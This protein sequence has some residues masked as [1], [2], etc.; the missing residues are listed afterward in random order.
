MAPGAAAQPVASPSAPDLALK[1]EPPAPAPTPAPANTRPVEDFLK[2]DPKKFAPRDPGVEVSDVPVQK[3]KPKGFDKSTAEDV[4]LADPDKIVT[5]KPS[6]EGFPTR[7]SAVQFLKDAGLNEKFHVGN[8]SEDG[9]VFVIPFPT[10][11]K[12]PTLHDKRTLDMTEEWLKVAPDSKVR[13]PKL[14]MTK[15]DTIEKSMVASVAEV[16]HTA[17]GIRVNLVDNLAERGVN[18]IAIHG[19]NDKSKR[20]SHVFVD[21]KV[22]DFVQT[23]GHEATHVLEKTSPDL[24]AR[25][26]EVILASRSKVGHTGY[27]SERMPLYKGRKLRADGKE[28]ITKTMNDEFTA[29]VSGAMWRDPQF[30]QRVYELDSGSTFRKLMYQFMKALNKVLN[31]ARARRIDVTKLVTD[32]DKVR[33]TA[34]QVWAEHAQRNAAP[35][36]AA[37]KGG[38]V[39]GV[40]EQAVWHGTPHRG[41]DKFSTDKIGTRDELY[42]NLAQDKAEPYKPTIPALRKE[43]AALRA[44][45]DCLRG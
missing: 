32:A 5:P 15:I 21:A 20:F 7:E 24:Y 23:I 16:V 3:G 38:T 39:D 27:L 9:T 26:Q 41:I 37:S 44:L 1:P 14:V 8:P 45:L 29:D 11:A 31:V 18:G 25:L 43:H 36:K 12:K 30:W 2:I 42:S 40:K 22:P 34:A 10:A 4:K 13:P 17:F 19:T 6:T 28:N 35:P 33:E